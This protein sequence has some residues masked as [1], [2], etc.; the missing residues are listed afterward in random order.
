MI[1]FGKMAAPAAMDRR[2]LLASALRAKARE[3]VTAVPVSHGQKALWFLHQHAKAGSAYNVGFS[4]RIRSRL[5]VEALRRSLQA[6]VDRHA[7]LRSRF[8]MIDGELMQEIRHY[9]PVAFEVTELGDCAA[10][11][12]SSQ[13]AAAYHRPFDLE[14]GPVFRVN[15]FSRVADDHILLLTASHIVYDGW[16]LWLN[17]DELG[18]LYAGE[19]AGRTSPLPLLHASY[20]DYVRRK[21]KMLS[22]AEGERLWC[23]WQA[24]L[25][26]ELPNLNLPTDHTRPP[27]QTFSG[28]SQKVRLDLDLAVRFKQIARTHGVTLSTLLLAAYQVLLHRYCG[29][30]DILVGVPTVGMR[31][32]EY[33]DVVGYFV[34]PVVVRADLSGNPAFNAFLAQL[35][36]TVLAAL[37]HQDFPFPLLVERLRLKRDASYSPLFQASFAFQRAQRAGGLLDLTVPDKPHARGTWGGLEVEAFDLAQQEGQFD[38]ELELIHVEDSIFGSFKYNADLFDAATMKEMAENFSVLLQGIAADPTQHVGNIPIL[39]QAARNRRLA[40]RADVQVHDPR[41][42]CLHD[43]FESHARSTPDA[44]ALVHADC[45]LTYGD[46]N[47]RAERLAKHLQ[48]LGVGPDTLVGLCMESSPEMVIGILGIL[49]AGGAYVPID[50]TTP[51]ARK[52]FILEDSAVQLLLTKSGYI[53]DLQPGGAQVVCLDDRAVLAAMTSVD[54]IIL[55]RGVTPDNLAY[56]IY[57]SGTTGNPKG[58]QITHRNVARLFAASAS[59]YDFGAKDVWSMFHSFAF[60]FSVWEMWG[61]LLHGGRLVL[62]PYMT[63][64]SPAAFRELVASEGVTVLNQTPSA[65]RLFIQ[66]DAEA[67]TA[68]LSLRWVIFGGEALDLQS[69]KPWYERH[70]ESK[71]CLVNMYGITETTVHVTRRLLKRNDLDCGRSVIG[72]PLPDLQVYLLDPYLQPVP[73]GVVGEIYVGGAGLAR[74]YLRRPELNSARFI[75]H[76][77]DPAPGARLYKSGDLGRYLRGGDIEY[78]GRVDNQVKIRGFRI[79]LGEIEATLESHPGVDAAVVRVMKQQKGG[80]KLIAYVVAPDRAMQGA[81]L[82]RFLL[83]RLPEY[84]VPSVFVSIERL[85]LTTN[86]KVDYAALPV[87]ETTRRDTEHAYVAPRDRVEQQLV[88][89]WEEVLEVAPIG[90]HDD[91]FDLGGDSLLAVTLVVQIERKFRKSLPVATLFRNPTIEKLAHGLHDSAAAAWSALVPLRAMGTRTPFFCVAGGA[92]N[93]LCFNQLARKLPPDRA[94]YGLQAVG[95]DGHSAPLSRVEDMAAEHI[96]EIREVQAHGPYLLGGHCFG[97]WIAFEMAHQLQQQGEEIGLV[98]VIDAPAPLP[99]PAPPAHDL[100]D[101][102]AWITRFGNIL[103]EATGQDLGVDATALRSLAQDA[104]LDYFRARLEAGAILPPDTPIAQVRGLMQVFVLNSKASYAP[105]GHSAPLALFRAAEFHPDYD[106]AAAEE[107]GAATA[108]SALGWHQ[109]SSAAVP[110]YSVSGNHITLLSEPHVCDLAE[111]IAR[112]VAQLPK[113]QVESLHTFN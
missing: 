33:A 46:L 58:V 35:H 22:G 96:K 43:A 2:A 4:I 56:V 29:Q 59:W 106:Y 80:D 5:D 73:D 24:Q 12:L 17:L 83:E 82:R 15:L 54:P 66:A 112:C 39:S 60:D 14:R 102:A 100:L 25:C 63:A 93:A 20:Q 30:D 48:K 34:N 87:P 113:L 110:V 85:P 86:G 71:P 42:V 99:R 64:R 95:L 37:E 111:Q 105:A 84:M 79:E 32:A 88:E 13:V 28:A 78:L 53:R 77:F 27:L 72:A 38:I 94:F 67:A 57:T 26:G 10:D 8:C 1:E 47:H 55:E 65:F 49:K 101:Q 69:L 45:R 36:Q 31:G 18:K 44:V 90:V 40:L 104:Q 23:F 74:G 52:A 50:P 107:P 91:F 41:L 109:F 9:E 3:Q 81:L 89:I 19:L 11:E 97:A 92:G 51:Q 61:A 76:P 103:S 70:G 68:P 108:E 75:A 98:V 6:L 16:S 7:S 21:H 62:V